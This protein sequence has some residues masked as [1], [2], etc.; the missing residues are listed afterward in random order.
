MEDHT[1]CERARAPRPVRELLGAEGAEEF[2][3]TPSPLVVRV[4]VPTN[5][6]VRV[7]TSWYVVQSLPVAGVTDE[8]QDPR[9]QLRVVRK[10]RDGLGLVDPVL[11]RDG[12][13]IEPDPDFAI[14][15]DTEVGFDIF[16]PSQLGQEV[17]VRVRVRLPILGDEVGEGAIGYLSNSEA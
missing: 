10:R 6:A 12:E 15:L 14:V 17:V 1:Q 5:L 2:K 7:R 4:D 8:R 13:D 9:A 3:A 11:L 16:Q